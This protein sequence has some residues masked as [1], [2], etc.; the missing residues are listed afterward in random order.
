MAA[1]RTPTR[2]STKTSA[3]KNGAKNG[4]SDDSTRAKVV[5]AAVAC[6]LEE[7]FYRA[8]SN[9]IARRAEV[10]WGVIQY[11]FGTREAMLLAVLERAA[12]ELQSHLNHPITGETLAERIDEL[13]DIMWD[14]YGKSD[15]LAYLQV[16]WNLSHDPTTEAQT[17]EAMND[18][19]ILVGQALPKLLQDVIGDALPEDHPDHSRLGTY[20][21]AALR[22]MAVDQAHIASLPTARAN[23]NGQAADREMLV[24]SLTA[25]VESVAGKKPGLLRRR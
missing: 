14:Y 22:G 23:P 12:A 1:R 20:V 5:D 18:N 16:M 10:T 8:S 15:F 24:A 11:H 7:G 25:Y 4:K 19:Q 3:P 2:T 9:E 6:I 21:F 17:R 13:A